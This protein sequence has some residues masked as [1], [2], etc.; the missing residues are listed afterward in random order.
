MEAE[1]KKPTKYLPVRLGNNFTMENRRFMSTLYVDK[2]RVSK[3]R[4][5][6]DIYI[7][8]YQKSLNT[9]FKTIFFD[10]TI[11]IYNFPYAHTN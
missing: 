2:E 8:V 10:T 7:F 5:F 6:S 9:P 3:V 4:L 1:W 11:S